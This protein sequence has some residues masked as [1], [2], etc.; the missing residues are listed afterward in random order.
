MGEFGEIGVDYGGEKMERLKD[1]GINWIWRWLVFFYGDL[2]VE[3][4]VDVGGFLVD[5][6]GEEFGCECI[7]VIECVLGGVGWSGEEFYWD[8]FEFL[9]FECF[10]EDEED[11][12]GD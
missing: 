7:V 3:G 8:G 5:E 9:F 6:F 1:E 12:S 2:V 4:G 10:L 11:D